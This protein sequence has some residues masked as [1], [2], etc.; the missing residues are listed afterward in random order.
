MR[1]LLEVIVTKALEF[2][3]LKKRMGD[4]VSTYSRHGQVEGWL[5]ST[6]P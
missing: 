6:W 3:H 5:I 1:L 2:F 4:E